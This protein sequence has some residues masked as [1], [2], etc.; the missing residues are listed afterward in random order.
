MPQL[1]EPEAV[2]IAIAGGLEARDLINFFGNAWQ[3]R[4]TTNLMED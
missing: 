1:P 2:I 3:V 4:S